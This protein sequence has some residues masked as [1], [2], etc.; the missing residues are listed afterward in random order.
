[1]PRGRPAFLAGFDFARQIPKRF[2]QVGRFG[3]NVAADF[4]IQVLEKCFSRL[5]G[6]G[7]TPTLG[8][9]HGE[10]PI[11]MPDH[12]LVTEQSGESRLYEDVR[13][14]WPKGP[15]FKSADGQFFSGVFTARQR[16]R[17]HLDRSFRHR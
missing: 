7:M 17:P 15:G 4:G 2:H 12:P 6:A 5:F 16:R 9:K 11:D 10:L 14:R 3:S 1:M 8:A 13:K